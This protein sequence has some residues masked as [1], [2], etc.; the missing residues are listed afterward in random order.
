M[1]SGDAIVS[2]PV[3]RLL[4]AA[5]RTSLQTLLASIWPGA[6]SDL[7]EV[8]FE[9]ALGGEVRV[10]LFGERT[11]APASIPKLPGTIIKRWVP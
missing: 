7:D 2:T 1:A 8:R 3:E 9:R 11:F 6:L 10:T 5:E 4:S